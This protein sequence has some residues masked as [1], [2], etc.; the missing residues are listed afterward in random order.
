MSYFMGLSFVEKK[1]SYQDEERSVPIGMRSQ[2]PR[3]QQ[4]FQML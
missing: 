3:V 2:L 4:S 1:S